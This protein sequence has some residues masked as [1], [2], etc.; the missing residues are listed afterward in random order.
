MW[1][2]RK[3]RRILLFLSWF[4]CVLVWTIGKIVSKSIIFHTVK[5]KQKMVVWANILYF[6]FV[7]TKSRSFKNALVWLKPEATHLRELIKK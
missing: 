3:N 5:N 2:R 7:E 6:V 4:S 1:R